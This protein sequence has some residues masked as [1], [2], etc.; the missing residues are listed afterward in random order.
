VVPN[1]RQCNSSP[2]EAGAARRRVDPHHAPA[3]QHGDR[4]VERRDAGEAMAGTVEEVGELALLL[5]RI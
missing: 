3:P 5:N 2:D 4:L 1:H